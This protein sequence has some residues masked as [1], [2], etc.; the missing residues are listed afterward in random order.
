MVVPGAAERI[1]S[2]FEEQGRHRQYLEKQVVEKGNR[3]ELAGTLVGGVVALATLVLCG[4]GLYLNQPLFALVGLVST[5][6]SLVWAVRGERS[7]TLVDMAKKRDI[8]KGF[9]D[10]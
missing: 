3:N 7:K 10:D 5:V 1:I 2:R 4:Y 8:S 6:A 9:A